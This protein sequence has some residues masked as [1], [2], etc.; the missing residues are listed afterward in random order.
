MDDNCECR[1]MSHELREVLNVSEY[2]QNEGL[3]KKIILVYNNE[4]DI[5]HNSPNANEP[6]SLHS[7]ITKYE[8]NQD[9][10]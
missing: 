3:F 8:W 6:M 2:Q 5:G 1:F 9:H 10:E 4:E 7:L